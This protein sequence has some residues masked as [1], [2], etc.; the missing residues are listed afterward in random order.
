MSVSQSWN[1]EL[2]R[3][4]AGLMVAIAG[5]SV[6]MVKRGVPEHA[7]K[8]KKP[9]EWT[10]YLE[11]LKVL[12]NLTDRLAAFHVP[13]QQRPNFMNSLED[14]VTAHLKNILA[15]ALSEGTD[16]TEVTFAVGRTVAE[17]RQLYESFTFM[18]TEDGPKKDEFFTFFGEQV[19]TVMGLAGN[20]LVIS[21]ASLCARAAVPALN[22]AFEGASAHDALEAIPRHPDASA[23]QVEP[24]HTTPS[25]GTGNEIKLISV[26]SAMAGEEIET[27]WGLHPRFRQ[28]LKPEEVRELTRLMNRLIRILGGRYAAVAF[29]A[30]WASWHQ[31][32]GHA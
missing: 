25:Q 12:F 15:P 7:L 2:L 14:A 6:T 17:S 4:L 32:M 11:F 3:E 8:L 29:S 10:I 13:V 20:G 18:V 28:D 9:Q 27:R 24:S 21:N 19:A 22:A 5:E 16:T 1:S 30:E 31:K 23:S 26:M